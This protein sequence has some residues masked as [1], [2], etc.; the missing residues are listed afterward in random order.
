MRSFLLFF[1][2]LVI[3]LQLSA[4]IVDE[5]YVYKYVAAEDTYVMHKR[6]RYDYQENSNI[7]LDDYIIDTWN[8]EKATWDPKRRMFRSF[9]DAGYLI[10]MGADSYKDGDWHLSYSSEYTYDT[11]ANGLPINVLLTRKSTSRYAVEPK[12]VEDVENSEFM[13]A[14]PLKMI[15]SVHYALRYGYDHIFDDAGRLQQALI[16]NC[17]NIRYI[18]NYN[19]ESEVTSIDLHRADQS[20][21]FSKWQKVVFSPDAPL[22]TED[23]LSSATFSLHPNPT[24][25]WVTVNFDR[26]ADVP[27]QLFVVDMLGQQV[28]LIDCE[29]GQTA[30][31]FNIE[32]LQSGTY[33]IRSEGME[34]GLPLMKL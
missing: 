12:L 9:D 30:V 34:R 2:F 13:I 10:K 26:P 32:N 21:N 15:F 16:S 23:I 20:G 28:K 29:A 1:V 18:F 27:E 3:G 7:L 14:E 4:Q 6:Y 33:F 8:D 17:N 19:S 5:V 22:Q 24:M 11:D 31:Q 25:N